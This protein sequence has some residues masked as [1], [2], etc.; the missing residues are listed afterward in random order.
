MDS[1]TLLGLVAA[2]LTT[3]SF[4]PQVVKMRKSK[5]TKDVS[6]GMFVILCTGIFLWLVYGVFTNSLPLIAANSVTLIL[7][8]MILAMKLK[9]K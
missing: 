8:L 7:G 1:L 4:V 3:V 9:Y 2:T 5:S 6:L